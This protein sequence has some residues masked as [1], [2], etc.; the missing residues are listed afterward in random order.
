M[1]VKGLK[2]N[3]RTS[4]ASSATPSRSKQSTGPARN[5]SDYSLTIDRE[6]LPSGVSVYDVADPEQYRA[7]FGG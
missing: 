5:F 3:S 1:P 2:P 6:N 7:L 4:T